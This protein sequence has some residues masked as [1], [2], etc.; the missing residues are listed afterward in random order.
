MKVVALM[1]VIAALMGCTTPAPSA[2][3]LPGQQVRVTSAYSTGSKKEGAEFNFL[4]RLPTM[5]SW[6]YTP[7]Y[8]ME[9]SGLIVIEGIAK[10]TGITYS[11]SWF[12]RMSPHMQKNLREGNLLH[13]PWYTGRKGDGSRIPYVPTEEQLKS[14]DWY[15]VGYPQAQ[16]TQSMYKGKNSFYCVRALIQRSGRNTFAQQQD[17]PAGAAYAVNY[18]CGFRTTDGRDAVFSIKTGFFVSAEAATVDPIIVDRKLAE[19]DAMLQ[20]S[21]DSLEVMPLAYQFEEP[22]VKSKKSHSEPS[23]LKN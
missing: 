16:F 8:K 12:D 9:S 15:S 18:F 10:G 23:N 3:Y 6:T 14:G 4:I 22:L 13:L 11:W 20:S 17:V 1:I 2:V 21:W 19:I 7:R 5:D